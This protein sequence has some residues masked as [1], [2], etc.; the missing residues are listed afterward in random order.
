[1][2]DWFFGVTMVAIKALASYMNYSRAAGHC[3]LSGP[4]KKYG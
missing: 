4:R 1:M 3:R 2:T